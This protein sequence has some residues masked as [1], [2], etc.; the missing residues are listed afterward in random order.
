[1]KP[2]KEQIEAALRYAECKENR[3]DLRILQDLPKSIRAFAP[4]ASEILSAA[5]REL[6]AEN[7][8]LTQQRDTLYDAVS[9]MMRLTSSEAYKQGRKVLTELFRP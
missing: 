1:M 9:L 2:T 3:D 6:L 8:E 4:F 7:A 5:Y